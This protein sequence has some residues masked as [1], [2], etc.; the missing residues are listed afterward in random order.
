M[1]LDGLIMGASAG[2]CSRRPVAWWRLSG[3]SLWGQLGCADS[4]VRL[5]T[6]LIA[7]LL[8]NQVELAQ[9]GRA[10]AGLGVP[11]LWR[12]AGRPVVVV[13]VRL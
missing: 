13:V 11:R 9:A 7:R 10:L 2:A 3:D 1:E 5:F 4:L 12:A 6:L 8:R